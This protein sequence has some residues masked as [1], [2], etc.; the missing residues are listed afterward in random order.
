MSLICIQL[1]GCNKTNEVAQTN[2]S[3]NT[4]NTDTSKMKITINEIKE[5]LVQM[6]AYCGF[7]RSLNGINTFM[8]VVN[9]VATCI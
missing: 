1:Y 7:P 3:N 4:S 9:L 6:Y 2:N 8:T 5:V